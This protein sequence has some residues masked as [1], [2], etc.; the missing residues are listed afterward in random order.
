[1]ASD[2]ADRYPL[3]DGGASARPRGRFAGKVAL[4]TGASD[5]GIGGAIANRLANEGA[6]VALAS[7][8]PP[9]RRAQRP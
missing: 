4:I 5:H 3:G 1:M 2:L 9:Q 7:R 8:T 6:S